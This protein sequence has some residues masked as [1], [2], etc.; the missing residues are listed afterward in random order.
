MHKIFANSMLDSADKNPDIW[1][2]N[3]EAL[4]QR[5]DDI[6]LVGRMSDMEFM[7]HVLN[8]L[9]EEYD[10]VLYSLETR[11]VS[12]GEDRLTLESLREKLNSR[13]ERIISKEREKDCNERAL[14]AGFNVQFKGTCRK[15]GENG[16]KSD[17][18]KCPKNQGSDG[19]KKSESGNSNGGLN[20]SRRSN[21]KFWNCR[22]VLR[23]RRPT[24]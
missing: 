23:E 18:L 20:E 6:G 15:C 16:H 14:A 17:S 13:F 12:T 1:I 2:T 22:I 19:I 10:V 4:R 5:M 24:K 11:L 8:N 21:T 3:L 9:P 7:I